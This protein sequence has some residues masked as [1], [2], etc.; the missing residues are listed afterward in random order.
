M[1]YLN[2]LPHTLLEKPVDEI[3]FNKNHTA[4]NKHNPSKNSPKFKISFYKLKHIEF[5]FN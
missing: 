3:P 1:L 2:Y 5:I 4:L